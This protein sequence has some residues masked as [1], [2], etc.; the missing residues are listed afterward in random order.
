M[1]HL[2]GAQSGEPAFPDQTNRE[3]Q[4]VDFLIDIG[5][6][7]FAF[8]H[9]RIAQFAEAIHLIERVEGKDSERYNALLDALHRELPP[10]SY[11]VEMEPLLANGRKLDRLFSEVEQWVL[12]QFAGMG[13]L[14]KPVT[15]L[16]PTRDRSNRRPMV[17]IHA[18]PRLPPE[19]TSKP[20]I[21]LSLGSGHGEIAARES[22]IVKAF[23]DKA[24][25]LLKYKQQRTISVLVLED[26]ALVPIPYVPIVAAS[27]LLELGFSCAIDW[28]VE[29][30]PERDI[31][32][33]HYARAG[34]PLKKNDYSTWWLYD[35][36][37][38][39]LTQYDANGGGSLGQLWEAM[40]KAG[41]PRPPVHR[42]V[43]P[44]EGEPNT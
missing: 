17:T 10:G 5:E 6:Q 22:V 28:V 18:G 25:K 12:A 42:H 41:L 7:R 44:D 14:T 16:Y 9:T 43:L 40:E 34:Q 21:L 32:A 30:S 19:D 33:L 3:T 24:P 20:H 1:E 37:H 27:R 11:V 4:D 29:V 31:W 36:T 2:Y 26:V 35:P 39:F 13:P 23:F 8:E 15:C 38:H